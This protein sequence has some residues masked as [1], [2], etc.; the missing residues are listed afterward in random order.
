MSYQGG[1]NKYTFL[2][3][4]PVLR[5]GRTG[6]SESWAFWAV[7]PRKEAEQAVELE[8][9]ADDDG[10]PIKLDAPKLIDWIGTSALCNSH[11]VVQVLGDPYYHHR[12]RLCNSDF[13]S[14]LTGWMARDCG[15]PGRVFYHAPS[16]RIFGGPSG[17][18]L[19]IVW[20]G[21]LDV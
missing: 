15:G 20:R 7:V 16:I 6:D 17:D 3:T 5:Q 10:E 4:C 2:G 1:F 12:K 13:A 19:L 9:F 18:R 8:G 11:G 21:G 14:A